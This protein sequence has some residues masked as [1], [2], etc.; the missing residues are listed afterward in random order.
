MQGSAIGV[1]CWFTTGLNDNERGEI[2]DATGSKPNDMP[3][4]IVSIGYDK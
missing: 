4:A 1:G 3:A 2:R